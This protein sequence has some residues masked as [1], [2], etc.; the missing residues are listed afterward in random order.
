M[1]KIL[2]GAHDFV[3][4][5]VMDQQQSPGGWVPGRGSGFGV[6]DHG[7]LIAGVV[8]DSWNGASVQMHVA[9]LPGRNW[10]SKALLGIV[11]DYP[12]NQLKVKKILGTVGESNVAARRFDEHVGFKLE[13]TLSEAHPDGMLLVYSMTREQCRWLSLAEKEPWRVKTESPART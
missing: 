2:V 5:W 12:F 7:E 10:V 8:F 4:A 3:G 6:T 1:T 11:F 9:A 13:A